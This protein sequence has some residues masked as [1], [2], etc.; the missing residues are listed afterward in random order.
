[1]GSGRV[2]PTVSN[3]GRRCASF[4]VSII[5]RQ[6]SG[7]HVGRFCWLQRREDVPDC[8]LSIH[9]DW[10]TGTGWTMG[11]QLEI[12]PAFRQTCSISLCSK[13]YNWIHWLNFGPVTLVETRQLDVKAD[14]IVRIANFFITNSSPK[15]TVRS[16]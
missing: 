15:S 5:D 9:K 8:S 12:A 10:W 6:K 14:E 4:P 13:L 1:M 16:L 7:H 2:L 11:I 3:I